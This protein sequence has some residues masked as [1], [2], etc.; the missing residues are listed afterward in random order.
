[1]EMYTLKTARDIKKISQK[2]A[3]ELLNISPD[4][5]RHYEQGK[6]FPDVKILK[7]MEKL[8]GVNYSQLIFLGNDN[9]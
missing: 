5:L 9:A 4:T 6:S 8:Y 7:Q 2:K 3:A 1:M